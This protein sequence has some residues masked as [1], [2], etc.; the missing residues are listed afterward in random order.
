MKF[1]TLL[2][3]PD[4]DHWQWVALNHE[5]VSQQLTSN[6]PVLDQ[7]GRTQQIQNIQTTLTNWGYARQP[8]V[9]ALPDHWCLSASLAGNRLKS[10]RQNTL[11]DF[12]AH[13]PISLEDVV[14]DYL[15]GKD[16]TL[17]VCTPLR[18]LSPVITAIESLN[19]NLQSIC[20]KAMLALQN[21]IT[22]AN[23]PAHHDTAWANGKAYHWFCIADSKPTHWQ[24]L[25]RSE[26]ALVLQAQ[27][28]HLVDASN[29]ELHLLDLPEADT[30]KLKALSEIDSTQVQKVVL[31]DQAFAGAHRVATRKIKPWFNLLRP[32]LIANTKEQSVQRALSM[33]LLSVL[34]LGITLA[35]MLHWR[36]SEYQ[37]LARNS[38]KDQQ[39]IF[40]EVFPEARMPQVNI[41]SRMESEL[42]RMISHAG[43]VPTLSINEDQ[44]SALTLLHAVLLSLPR[45]QALD[46]QEIRMENNRIDIHGQAKQ[47]ADVQTI[48]NSLRAHANLN[49]DTP[50]MTQ[51]RDGII[52]YTITANWR[53]SNQQGGQR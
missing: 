3:I 8:V 9:I 47:H 15:P 24:W 23:P 2:L 17:G 32:P 7:P 42:R 20:P 25:D 10:A 37:Q 38:R 21:R 28:Q 27:T 48:A 13:W 19:L 14:V 44:T 40:R 1:D 30:F 52:R 31:N 39:A 49:V 6:W 46:L 34:I 45:D 36:A 18:K 4:D 5:S 35:G 43:A 26:K 29:R 51:T 50:Q 11:F 53:N 16:T 12:E 33:L 22:T 41:A